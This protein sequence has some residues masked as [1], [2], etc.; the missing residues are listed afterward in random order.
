MIKSHLVNGA[1]S[2]EVHSVIQNEVINALPQ[3]FT[4]QGKVIG[5]MIKTEFK[6]DIKIT[7][8]KKWRVPLQLQESVEKKKERPSQE[9]QWKNAYSKW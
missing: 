4:G 8:Q 3:F 6:L 1:H 2:S 9:Q 5:H 7:Q